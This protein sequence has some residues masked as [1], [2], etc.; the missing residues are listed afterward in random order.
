MSEPGTFDEAIAHLRGQGVPAEQLALLERI[1]VGDRSFTRGQPG[2]EQITL[3]YR[4]QWRLDHLDPAWRPPRHQLDALSKARAR[5]K[6]KA[7]RKAA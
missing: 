2:F 3:H 5:A 4:H 6:A 1:T 7:R